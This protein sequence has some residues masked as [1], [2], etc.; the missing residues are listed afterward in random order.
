MAP[1]AESEEACLE[2]V[3]PKFLNRMMEVS[4]DHPNNKNHEDAF[5]QRDLLSHDQWGGEQCQAKP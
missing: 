1:G 3:G 2:C 5:P 4:D